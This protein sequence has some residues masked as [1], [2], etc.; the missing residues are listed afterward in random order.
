MNISVAA[1]RAGPLMLFLVGILMLFG[2][3]SYLTLPAREDPKLII[4][5]AVVTTVYPG[6]S[7]DQ[8]ELLITKPLEERIMALPNIRDIASTSMNG[9]SII[10]PRFDFDTP[11]LELAF[12]NLAETVTETVPALPEGAQT[13]IVNDD[14]GDIAAMTL[15]LHGPEYSNAELAEYAE[16]VRDQ[17]ILVEGTKKVDLLGVRPE[18]IF[19]E[20]DNAVLSQAGISPDAIAAALDSENTIRPGGSVE[21]ADGS[22]AVRPGGNFQNIDDV[23]SALVRSPDGTLV[24]V[25]DIAAVS[26]GYEDPVQRLAYYNKDETV[27]LAV[28]MEEGL[29]VLNYSAV[30]RAEVERIAA[31]LPVGLSLD[32]V[33][34]EATKVEAAVYGVTFNMLQTLAVVLGIVILFLGVRTGLIVGAIIPAVILATFAVMGAFEIALQRMSLATIII[35]LGLLVDNGIV[36]AEDFKRRVQELGDRDKALAQT[37]REL[38]FPLLVSSLTTIAVFLPLLIANSDS[39]EYTRSISL[40]VTISLGV[41][42]VFAMTVTTTLC[43]HFLKVPEAGSADDAEDEKTRI[44]KAFDRLTDIY[45]GI[46]RKL[47]AFRWLYVAAMVALFAAAGLLQSAIPK[48]FF[49]SNNNPQVL[50]YIELA[51][52]ATSSQTDA[53]V[54]DIVKLID[55]DEAFPEVEDFAAYVG[56]G[57]PRFVLSLSPVDPAP[58]KGFIVINTTDLAGAEAIVPRLR[59]VFA[60]RVPD[61]NARVTRMFLGPEDP[62]VIRLQVT[63]PD[64]DY[65][66]AR[67]GDVMDMLAA[68]PGMID[69]WSDWRSRTVEVDL[70]VDQQAA[71]AAGVTSAAIALSLQRQLDG[72][73]VSTF[74]EGDES[75]PIVMRGAEDERTSIERL[76]TAAVYA[77]DGSSVPLGQVAEL[78]LAGEWGFIQREDMVR[79]VTVEG[80]HLRMSPDDL[81]PQL[82]PKIDAM[83]AD[84]APGHNIKI[85]GILEESGK[86]NAALIATL[87][88]VIGMTFFLLIAQFGDFRR[89]LVIFLSLPFATFGAFFGLLVMQSPFGFM[90]ILS[91]FALFGVIIN[92]SIV[93]VDRIDIERNAILAE[94]AERPEG[95]AE[96]SASLEREFE[97]VISACRRR[98][99]P[100]VM[101]TLTTIAG[102]LPLIIAQDVLFYGFASSVAFG[103]LIGTFVVSL[104]L[105]PVLYCLFFGIR[106]P[107]RDGETG[108]G[109]ADSWW[110]RLIAK[111]PI[112]RRGAKA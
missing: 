35:S 68:E 1:L 73:P 4:R 23:R 54:R 18:R 85:A 52:G 110:R 24:R 50:V 100:V 96:T 81:A 7:A 72:Q 83:N 20:F 39:S 78:Q 6:L 30:A 84:L 104:A 82:Q 57:G 25:E 33:T 59:E 31:T 102:L 16:H 2:V 66:N 112:A 47:L 49:P 92:N 65:I 32:I 3:Y 91:L 11:D 105:T 36:I 43:Y 69:I 108:A 75:F 29:S 56:F 76:R 42:Y 99:R 80:R 17:L 61:I 5:Q 34:Y 111:L 64:A 21:V 60:A 45:A 10:K 38:A 98:F 71:R 48:E 103:L 12:E 14:F 44:A 93:L 62:K 106:R 9:V 74:R 86:N 87:P 58:N 95:A 22:I 67:A 89:P 70:K 79:T 77:A 26:R 55:D 37:S 88:I 13:P 97:A 101:T 19:V 40:V 90:A 46:L 41:S 28:V 107:D 51:S 15:A 27:I 53:G 109:Q 8:V 63:G 94:D